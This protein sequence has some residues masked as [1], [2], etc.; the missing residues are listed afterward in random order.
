MTERTYSV[1]RAEPERL[2]AAIATVLDRTTGSSAQHLGSAA[3]QGFAAQ[4]ADPEVARTFQ[5]L[6]TV[7]YLV[8]SSDQLAAGERAAL[9]G[10]LERAAG[11]AV[12]RAMFDHRLA[13]IESLRASLGPEEA[14]R[15][16]A[17]DLSGP[18]ARREAIV[19]A[20]LV[21]IGDGTLSTHEVD[22]LVQLGE[23]VQVPRGEV[24]ALIEDVVHSVTR[25]LDG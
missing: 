15:R 5:A 6:L 24:F 9:A 8:A 22:T 21:S 18:F 3:Q 10:V 7:G 13:E 14:L 1:P 4:P 25:A 16:A 20:A 17:A 2:Q 11:S 23:L 12:D 19:F